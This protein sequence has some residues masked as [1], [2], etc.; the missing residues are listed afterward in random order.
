MPIHD[1]TL[2]ETLS[3]LVMQSELLLISRNL[4]GILDWLP[5]A[6]RTSNLIEGRRDPSSAMMTFLSGPSSNLL[7]PSFGGWALPNGRHAWSWMTGVS[8]TYS[9]ALARMVELCKLVNQTGAGCVG[10]VDENPRHHTVD[11]S[12]MY[13]QR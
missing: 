10:A 6:L 8:V 7:A 5:K 1:W 4:S 11:S 13:G 9:A 2:E 3:G 12:N